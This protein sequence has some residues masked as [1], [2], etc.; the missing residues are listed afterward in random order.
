[1]TSFGNG[2]LKTLKSAPT[3]DT[4]RMINELG[5]VIHDLQTM[6]DAAIENGVSNGDKIWKIM[7][8]NVRNAVR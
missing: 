8:G 3:Q 4:D 2:A 5:A 1:M 7:N 6:G